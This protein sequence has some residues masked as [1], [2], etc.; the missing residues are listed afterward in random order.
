MNQN[1]YPYSPPVLPENSNQ[2]Q[3]IQPQYQSFP[4]AANQQYPINQEFYS[5][6]PQMNYPVYAIPDPQVN[7]QQVI[8]NSLYNTNQSPS[9]INANPNCQKCR[10]TGFYMRQ[11]CDGCHTHPRERS[12][13]RRPL[14]SRR[15]FG[16][17]RFL[18]G[19]Y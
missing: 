11:P 6:N 4:S 17:F 10:G 12:P 13:I 18:F 8:I 5:Q 14:I 7:S 9:M 2:N 1:I 16:L 15:R 3:V 19:R